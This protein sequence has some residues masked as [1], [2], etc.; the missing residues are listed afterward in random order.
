MKRGVWMLALGIC[1]I[2]LG[3]C[4]AEAGQTIVRGSGNLTSEDRPVSG[5]HERI[6]FRKGKR[7]G[8]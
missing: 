3:A 2:S 7:S 4:A 8:G 6:E 1:L 5:R